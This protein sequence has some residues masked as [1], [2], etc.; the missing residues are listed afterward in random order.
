MPGWHEL[1]ESAQEQPWNQVH[2]RL[3]NDKSPHGECVERLPEAY[4][5]KCSIRCHTKWHLRKGPLKRGTAQY[6]FPHPAR[7]EHIFKS[8][9][10][11]P[12][13]ETD[14]KMCSNLAGCGNGYCVEWTFSQVP[15]SF[16]V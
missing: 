3:D 5:I 15:F 16:L 9:D 6:P 2:P 13:L 12:P 1:L 4:T 14:L 7:F 11:G 8:V 10:S